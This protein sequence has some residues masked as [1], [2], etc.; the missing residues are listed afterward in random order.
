MNNRRNA[1]SPTTGWG[2]GFWVD[3]MFILNTFVPFPKIQ[4][5]LKGQLLSPLRM[6][7]RT[8]SP[9][10][11]NLKVFPGQSQHRHKHIGSLRTGLREWCSCVCKELC[12]VERP[13]H[14]HYSA[15]TLH[16]SSAL[17]NC[18][19]AGE[20]GNFLWSISGGP[21]L[22]LSVAANAFNKKGNSGSQQ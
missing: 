15:V 21:W 2:T 13:N 20:S 1:V 4:F 14:W 8:L 5:T 17:M 10:R 19:Y 9:W 16:I 12:R 6:F 18:C 3:Q 11:G 22:S 7:K